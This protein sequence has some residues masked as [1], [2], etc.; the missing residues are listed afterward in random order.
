MM[1][2]QPKKVANI[3]TATLLSS[4]ISGV[5]YASENKAEFNEGAVHEKMATVDRS[6]IK[7][8]NNPLPERYIIKFKPNSSSV[9][10]YSVAKNKVMSKAMALGGVIKQE[11]NNL[12][13]V[14]AELSEQAANELAQDNAIAYIEKDQPR[15]IL[16]QDMP[17]G[18]SMVQA[19]MVDDS[20]A[21]AAS[22]G[23]KICVIDSGIQLP[24][25][26]M[27]AQGA[28]VS[29]TNDSGTGNWFDHGGPHG[30]HVA[31]TI[32]ALNNGIGVRGV[33]GSDPNVH[34]VKVFN[35]SGWGYSSN[36]ASAVDVCIN[37]GAQVINMSLGGKSST[38]T[39]KERMD[40]AYQSGI[41]LIAAAGNSGDV[42][43][44]VDV[45][46]YPASYDSVVSVAA[47]DDKKELAGFSQKNAQI[48]I[49]AP[50]VDIVST[51]PH[52]LGSEVNLN[53]GSTQYQSN[54]MENQGTAQGSL[55]DFGLGN[56][57]DNN[58]SGKVCLIQRG[59][60]SFHDKVKNCESS[61]GVGAVI[62]NNAAGNFGATLGDTNTTSIPAVSASDV[63]GAAMLQQLGQTTKIHI[64]PGNYGKMSGTSMASPHVA[65]VAALVWSTY[66]NCT[67]QA[68]RKVLNLTAEDLGE[69]GRD[70]KFGYGLVQTKAAIDYI[71]ANGC[72]FDDDNNQE[73][74][75]LVN[76]SPETNINLA[77]K[78][79]ALYKMHVPAEAKNIRFVIEGGSGDADMYVRA[80][81]APTDVDYD[82]RPYKSGSSESCTMKET[83]VTYFVRVKAFSEVSGLTLS[84]SYELED[85][86]GITKLI[87]GVA[88]TGLAGNAADEAFYSI[89]VPEGMNRLEVNMLGGS[90]DADLYVRFGDKPTSSK[91]DCRPYKNGN[92]ES[93]EITQ[94]KA[95]TYYVM[96][97]GYKAYSGVELTA[98]YSASSNDTLKESG[99]S[100]ARRS[101][102]FFTLEV[103]AGRSQVVISMS[104]GT[105]DADLYVRHGNQPTS[106]KYDCRPYKNGNRESCT[107]TAKPGT[108][109]IMLRGFSNYSGVTLQG[110]SY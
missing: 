60:I 89:E 16:S 11:F 15:R 26:D 67:N 105:G 33:I 76:G 50:G 3:L 70:I 99:L 9:A 41:L 78:D 10:K 20:V 104:G 59:E 96:L 31:G 68:I 25:E 40:A 91:Y 21:S 29:G 35:Q 85:N 47:I 36:L 100:G 69:T 98:T 48:E 72:T 49:A 93:C 45:M 55:Y 23:K 79:E 13:V 28:T 53:V 2:T 54:S 34:I 84:G 97:R 24:H 94:V 64:G 107:L 1:K 4:A 42:D 27:G 12:Q 7:N 30:T 101:E 92:K 95:G 17:Y 106:T 81:Q 39:E 80:N 56:Q 8:K 77:R 90:G 83:D 46:S 58:A 52:G 103:P 71:A 73:V 6:A 74:I 110:R 57:T 102:Q 5:L 19:D 61:G 75:E 88:A 87:N 32:A 18:I 82:C 86:N 108:Y 37:N 51:Y 109:H 38:T 43:K 44:E 14:T 22:G 63:D 65:G 66:P 62:Y